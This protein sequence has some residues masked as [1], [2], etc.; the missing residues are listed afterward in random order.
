ME[1][2][3]TNTFR[4]LFKDYEVPSTVAT[5]TLHELVR[6]GATYCHALMMERRRLERQQGQTLNGVGVN[7]G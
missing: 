6:N 1:Q 7:N 5:K 3:F 2:Q 4:T